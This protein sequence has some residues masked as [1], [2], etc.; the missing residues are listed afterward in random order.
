MSEKSVGRNPRSGPNRQMLRRT[1]FLM[2]VCGI[3]VFIVLLMRLYKLQIVDHEYYESL[4]IS[5]QLREVSGSVN[6]GTIYDSKMIPLAISATVDNVYLSPAEI[7][8]YGED[9]ELIA[10]GLSEILNMDYE[11]VYKKCQDSSS[12]YVTVKKKVEQEQ[13]DAVRAFKN[14][15]GLKGVRL[16]TDTKRYYPTSTLACHLIGFVGTDNYG[17]EVIVA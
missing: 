8:L 13:A 5:Q 9:K 6:R 2:S 16:E 3:A 11:E 15:H 12:W 17:L 7:N 14:E 10:R 4:A 1:L